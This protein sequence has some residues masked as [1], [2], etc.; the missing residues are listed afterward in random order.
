[1]AQATNSFDLIEKEVARKIT[2]IVIITSDLEGK[3]SPKRK[4]MG[5][6]GSFSLSILRNG[7]IAVSWTHF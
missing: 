7:L 4:R 5:N 1:M 2:I 3:E 6:D